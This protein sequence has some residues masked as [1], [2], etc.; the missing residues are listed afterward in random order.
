MYCITFKDR[1]EP[2]SS[3]TFDFG[4]DIVKNDND[5]ISEKD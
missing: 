1:A 2:N 3:I 5:I 4:T